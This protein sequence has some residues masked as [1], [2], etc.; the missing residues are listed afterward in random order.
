VIGCGSAAVPVC[1]ALHHSEAAELAAAC[2]INASLAREIGERYQ[3]PFTTDIAQV[4]AD[5][6]IDAV[7]IALPHRLL[8]PIARRALLAGKHT[9]VEK[10]MALTLGDADGLA[11]LAQE[12]RLGLGVFFELRYTPSFRQAR[13]LIGA[14]AIGRVIGMHIQTLIDKPAHYWQAGYMNRS[15]SPWRGQAALAGGGV[16][17]MNSSHQ[18]DAVGYITGLEIT[19]V[20]AEIGTLIAPVEVE[21]TAAATLRFDNGA[22][23]SL[24]AGA[25]M[26]GVAQ[27]ERCDIFGTE[28]QLRLADPYHASTAELYLRR[29][30]EG[31]APDQ[32]HALA[33]D[34]VNCYRAAVDDFAFAVQ[35]GLPPPIPARDARRVLAA[36]LAMYQSARER[37][38]I[39]L[40]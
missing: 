14:G 1:E 23:G 4:L 25:H 36:V 35:R 32:W 30:W 12:R 34:C 37:R 26:P 7:Y 2:D 27:A 11:A 21:D 13:A 24:I 6:G 17:L 31:F 9:L 5:V 3:V 20:A 10:P 22:I 29:P 15:S 33:G 19:S 40:R 38:H 8:A 39:D 16:V 28:G 18:L